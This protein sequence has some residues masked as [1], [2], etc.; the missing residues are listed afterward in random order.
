M[1]ASDR[2]STSPS[3]WAKLSSKAAGIS[4]QTQILQPRTTAYCFC[5]PDWKTRHRDHHCRRIRRV[6]AAAVADSDRWPPSA[7][8]PHAPALRVP[9]RRQRDPRGTILPAAKRFACGGVDLLSGP[10]RGRVAKAQRGSE[11]IKRSGD[12]SQ[13]CLH[14]WV[15]KMTLRRGV[16]LRCFCRT[17]SWQTEKTTTTPPLS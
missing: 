15:P 6:S 12:P 7:E 17:K 1:S 5:R 8:H 16:T 2:R 9:L 10:S 11:P 3:D 14:C 13:S 4:H